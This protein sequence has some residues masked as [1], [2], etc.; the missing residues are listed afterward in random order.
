MISFTA[1]AR[2]RGISHQAVY[3]AVK[4]G[5]LAGA[6][7][8][9]AGKDGLS[10]IEAA[11]RE[12]AANTDQSKPRNSV[13]GQPKRDR[14]TAT[15]AYAPTDGA[16]NFQD[17]PSGQASAGANS[18]GGGNATYA[19]ARAMRE[20]Y[21]ARDVKMSHDQRAGT[22]VEAEDVRVAVFSAQRETRDMLLALPDRLAPLIVGNTSAHEI[23]RLI[24]DEVRRICIALADMKLP[25]KGGK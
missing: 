19:K 20:V 13:T 25:S 24:T 8:T 3:K 21:A 1:Y 4:A 17:R 9:V 6:I 2:H 12:W 11:D 10:S 7:V 5:R 15:D 22:L 23:H 18:P 14:N 16:D